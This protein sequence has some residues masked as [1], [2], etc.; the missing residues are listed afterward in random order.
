MA[1]SKK[2][3][4]DNGV[5]VI[6]HRVVSVTK[7]TNVQNTIELASYT[8]QEKRNEEI[9]AIANSAEMNVYI[10]TQFFNT[11]YDPGMSIRLA[12]DWIKTNIPD[13][14]DAEDIY[15]IGD[16]EETDEVTGDEFVSM[17]EEV[18]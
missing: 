11:D 1:L 10:S 7:I 17:L 12:Y 8:S 4:L 9:E 16:G 18:L 6:Y 13:F 5:T 15:D 14:S 3:E 2:I